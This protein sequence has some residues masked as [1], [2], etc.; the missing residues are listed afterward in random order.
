MVHGP[1]E[2]PQY[3]SPVFNAGYRICLGKDMAM[4]EGKL[5]TMILLQKFT[6]KLAPRTGLWVKP[7][8]RTH[9]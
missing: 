2:R 8:K 3:T 9:E 6:F 1:V 4:L 5:I 7:K